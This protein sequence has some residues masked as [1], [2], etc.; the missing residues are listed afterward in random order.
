MAAVPD[1]D[2]RRRPDFRHV[3]VLHD[4]ETI[5]VAQR[6][7][8]RTLDVRDRRRLPET[9]WEIALASGLVRRVWASEVRSWTMEE[10]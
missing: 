1:V 6:D 7:A 2:L 3:F 9:V 8:I 5:I 4:G 10:A